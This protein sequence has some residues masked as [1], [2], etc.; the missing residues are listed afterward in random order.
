M[1]D[2]VQAYLQGI[3]FGIVL[4]HKACKQQIGRQISHKLI[5]ARTCS[6]TSYVKECG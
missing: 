6:S 1:S 3:Y 5:I 4:L 2:G